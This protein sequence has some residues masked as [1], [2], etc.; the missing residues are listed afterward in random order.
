MDA[1][2]DIGPLCVVTG[3]AGY[4]G[5]VLTRRLLDEGYR[6]RVFDFAD[7]PELDARAERVRG[8]L[9]DK[10]AV[11]AAIEGAHSVF[12]SASVIHLAGVASERTRRRVF[13]VNV[14][15]TENLLEACKEVGV[16]RLVYTS[17]NNVAFSGALTDADE[18]APYVE[19]CVDLYT[20]TKIAA[21]RRVLSA[22]R[23]GKL[24]TCAL[25]PGGLWG[26]YPGG[27]M[28]DK[29]LE[30]VA[31][32]T[33]LA[34]IGDGG[35]ADNTHVDNLA[36]A[37]LLAA[38]ALRSA[39][40]RVS[41]EAFF[42][43]DGEPMD[44]L[45]WFAP[46]LEELGVALPRLR[47]PARLL[48]TVGYGLEWLARAGGPE[49]MLTRIEVLKVSRPHAFRIDKARA[50]LGYTPRIKRI[51]G[52]RACVPYARAYVARRRAELRAAPLVAWRRRRG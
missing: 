16:E 38:R 42:I 5:R 31:R 37:H 3:G 23:A 24:R 10:R 17:T 12:H 28:L 41:G 30:Q 1:P 47:V 46:L 18:T 11:R 52:L 8:D 21:E 15:G 9:R 26:P 4:F 6:V 14:G 40:E 39:P 7:H 35:Y 36:D 2:F 43:T 20:E 33:L 19:R 44:P 32:G 51:E 34:R 49:P 29:V 22:G 13:E 50:L 25:R 27:V 45:E 48:Y